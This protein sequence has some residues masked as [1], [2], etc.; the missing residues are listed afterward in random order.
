MK[1]QKCLTSLQTLAWE[2]SFVWIVFYISQPTQPKP[3]KQATKTLPWL[4]SSLNRSEGS[5]V[6]NGA[7]RD[8]VLICIYTLLIS[9]LPAVCL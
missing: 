6:I 1:Y 3:F 8:Y 5:L 9:C 2:P 4:P 7:N